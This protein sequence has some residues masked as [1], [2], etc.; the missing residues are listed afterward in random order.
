MTK[1]I[2]TAMCLLLVLLYGSLSPAAPGKEKAEVTGLAVR[3]E[4]GDLLVSFRLENC[5]T[6]E[7]EKAVLSGV[8][9]TFRLR[10]VLEKSRCSLI[11]PA[12]LNLILEHSIK[13]DLLKKEFRVRVPEHP[14]NVCYTK[15]FDEAKRLMS[16][17][18]DLPVM[19]LSRLEKDRDY[20]IRIKAELSRFKMPLFLR[21]IFFFVSLWDFETSW[22]EQTFSL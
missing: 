11:Q 1:K 2:F 13:Y 17:V 3:Q 16:T 8:P 19:P 10:I 15:D 12:T 20:R 18:A 21:Y 22:Q 6:P 4:R 7:M 14:D 9:T 5:F